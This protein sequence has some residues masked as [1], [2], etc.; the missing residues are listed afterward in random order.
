[1]RW[2]SQKDIELQA[3]VALYDSV[4]WTAYTKDPEILGAMVR[5]STFVQSCWDEGQ[6]VGLVRVIS[7]DLSIM[8]LQDILVHPDF[9]RRGIGRALMERCLERFEHVRQKVLL[10]DNRP[11]QNA[12]YESLGFRNTRDLETTKLNAFVRIEGANLS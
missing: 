11:E 9:H 5:C 12:F 2:E 7:D 8:Y 3:L 10:T 4:G 1:M 6:L